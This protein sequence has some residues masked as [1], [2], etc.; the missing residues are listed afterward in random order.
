VRAKFIYEAI[1]HLKGRDLEDI[2]DITK[3]Y[4][5]IASHNVVKIL[6]IKPNFFVEVK[7][8]K[9][10]NN[11]F[12]GQIRNIELDTFIRVWQPINKVNEAIK[13]LK[14]RDLEEI[15]KKLIGKSFT[16]PG[17]K[18]STVRVIDVSND[19]LVK[20]IHSRTGHEYSLPLDTF[21]GSYNIEINEAIKHLAPRSEEEIR[22]IVF[23]NPSSEWI[24]LAQRYN[25]KLT[26]DEIRKSLEEEI[27]YDRLKI[28]Q[29][30]GWDWVYDE[31]YP[32]ILQ[33]AKTSPDIGS[34]LNNV[35]TNDNYYD[36]DDY[37]NLIEILLKRAK[38]KKLNIVDTEIY[39]YAVSA[40]INILSYIT[41]IPSSDFK[42]EKKGNQYYLIFDNWDVFAQ[43][44]KTGREIG[45]K[46]IKDM[47]AGEGDEH[48]YGY[49]DNDY[50]EL[51]DFGDRFLKKL[52]VELCNYLKSFLEKTN[53]EI[54]QY[55]NFKDLYHYIQK[56]DEDKKLDEDI[57]EAI[58]RAT[59]EVK[60]MADHDEAYNE[61]KGAVIDFFNISEPVWINDKFRTKI[62]WDGLNTLVGLCFS[63]E[64]I[65]KIDYHP[66]YYGW[67]GDIED[68]PVV[69]NDCVINRLEDLER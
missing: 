66:P 44:F 17:H 7:Y 9:V 35:I 48:F 20:F 52:D 39:A 38:E 67:D 37:K 11:N 49:Y 1:K 55:K 63:D 32:K 26:K 53:P 43:F 25:I 29:Y 65:D 5:N 15:K 56:L 62:S 18:K 60:E 68:Y 47:L 2:L 61:I 51:P 45:E 40:G 36:K 33:R 16:F 28:A 10:T 30:N 41:E 21:T 19:L 13:H 54:K 46:F 59:T 57:G 58:T 8:L 3:L 34:V 14:G 69:F 22:K 27:I 64:M 31:V 23:D 42:F 24:D 12:V 4:R 50:K 6:S